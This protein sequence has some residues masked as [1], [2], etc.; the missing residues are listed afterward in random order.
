[1]VVGVP[2]TLSIALGAC[3]NAGWLWFLM[4]RS[5]A[6]RPQPG[7]GA[8][9]LKLAVALYLMGGAIWYA[10]GTEA[11]WFEIAAG[12]RALKLTLVIIAG[13]FPEGRPARRA[14]SLDDPPAEVAPGAV[15]RG[16]FRK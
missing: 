5:G 11:S 4:Q 10:M 3:F 13:T 12:P 2:Q 16:P 9:L 8:F 15:A 6:Y 14:Q 1:M 7:W